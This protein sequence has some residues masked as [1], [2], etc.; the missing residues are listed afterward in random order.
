MIRKATST[1]WRNLSCEMRSRRIS[2]IRKPVSVI[3]RPRSDFTITGQVIS[4]EMTSPAPS[5][6][7][8]ARNRNPVVPMNMSFGVLRAIRYIATGGDQI[9]D[10]PPRTPDTMPTPTCHPRPGPTG[11][12]RPNSRF[13]EN[14]TI[15]MPM[16]TVSRAVG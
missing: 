3:S 14:T 12:D 11:N 4:P 15:A 1:I 13:S 7:Q 8:P 6:R 2:P 10:K 9:E 5:G 16:A